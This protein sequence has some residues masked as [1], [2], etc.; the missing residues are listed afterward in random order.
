[1]AASEI[2][3]GIPTAGLDAA[4]KVYLGYL[5]ARIDYVAASKGSAGAAGRSLNTRNEQCATLP[6]IEPAAAYPR[7]VR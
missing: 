5:Q 6:H 1:M 7:Y 2:I 4:D 3:A